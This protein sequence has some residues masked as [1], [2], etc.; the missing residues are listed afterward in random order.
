MMVLRSH[1]E[2]V[3]IFLCFLIIQYIYLDFIW[4]S[5]FQADVSSIN[6]FIKG[7][8]G[9]VNDMNLCKMYIVTLFS[10]ENV[11]VKAYVLPRDTLT[12]RQRQTDIIEWTALYGKIKTCLYKRYATLKGVG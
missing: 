2:G 6:A 8:L 12:L 9:L 10:P 11:Y 5:S 4:Q 7:A 3:S 1:I